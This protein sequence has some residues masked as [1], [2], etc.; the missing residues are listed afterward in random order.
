MLS[1]K[2]L[3]FLAASSGLYVAV[4][5]LA[6]SLLYAARSLTWPTDEVPAEAREKGVLYV[7]GF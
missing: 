4:H 7:S 5:T 1:A 2:G 3:L 6:I